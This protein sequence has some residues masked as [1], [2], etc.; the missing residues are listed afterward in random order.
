MGGL[1]LLQLLFR[2]LVQHRP[3]VSLRALLVSGLA[4]E[5]VSP[6]ALRPQR[7]H[8]LRFAYSGT[9]LHRGGSSPEMPR[10]L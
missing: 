5:Q 2:N 7:P 4:A 9:A 1:L 3:H 6:E 8:W 10:T